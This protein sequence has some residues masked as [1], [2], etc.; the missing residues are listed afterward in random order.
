MNRVMIHRAQVG[1][2]QT[3]A[4]T[5]AHDQRLGARKRLAVERQHVE[6]EH[7][8]RIG[9]TRAD[10]DFP[11]VRHQREVAVHTEETPWKLDY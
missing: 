8:S 9:A 6:V 7:R 3:H 4:L 11:F 5:A 10:F 1:E 2:A